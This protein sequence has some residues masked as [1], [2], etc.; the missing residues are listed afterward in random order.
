MSGDMGVH[1]A[2]WYAWGASAV[3][4]SAMLCSTGA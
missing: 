3:P 2:L 4:P 1:V